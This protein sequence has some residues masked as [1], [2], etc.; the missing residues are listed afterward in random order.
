MTAMLDGMKE[1]PW[2]KRIYRNRHG[3][4]LRQPV[5]GTH[6]PLY[7]TSAGYF[8]KQVLA[9]ITRL[10]R[11]WPQLFTHV[12]CAVEDVPP[13]DPLSWED[14]RVHLSQSFPSRHGI[15]ARI[16]LYRK[17][18]EF[19]ARNRTELDILI[20]DEIVRQLSELSGLPPQSIEPDW[21]DR[22]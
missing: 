13:S 10:K 8:D 22:F 7:R 9:Q 12:E 4:G 2:D 11:A 20:R 14:Y 21:Q 3:R 6:L 19:R 15:P 16:A 18:I 17:P 5:F 1:L